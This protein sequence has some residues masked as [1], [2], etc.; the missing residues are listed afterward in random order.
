[1]YAIILR[2]IAFLISALITLNSTLGLGLKIDE[3]FLHEMF[4]SIFQ[5]EELPPADE[6][7][8]ERPAVDDDAIDFSPKSEYNEGVVLV[9]VK[10]YFDKNDLGTLAFT[11]AEALFKGSKWYTVTLADKTAT[12][13]A[14]EYLSKLNSFESVDYDYVMGVTDKETENPNYNQQT[15]L[16]LSNIPYGWT[17][18]NKHPG[19]TSDVV[20]AVI[21]TGVDYTHL[22]L[23]NNIWVNTAVFAGHGKD[24]VG[25]G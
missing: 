14:V 22:D 11:S 20:V 23:R 16:G 25:N 17:Q 18:N 4:P 24:D 6:G 2:V 5:E 21:D 3:S 10:K 19:G 8:A 9:K 7:E 1:M 13:A 12:E 15:N